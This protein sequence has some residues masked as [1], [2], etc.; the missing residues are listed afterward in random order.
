M[1]DEPAQAALRDGAR[2]TTATTTA[3]EPAGPVPRLS[4]ETMQGRVY[5]EMR[6]AL[7]QGRFRPGEV[8]T[9]R[10]LAEM[11][12][13][14]PMPV[15]EAIRRLVGDGSLELLKSGSARVPVL[16]LQRFDELTDV[17]AVLEGH[18]AARAAEQMESAAFAA[19]RASNEHLDRLFTAGDIP[20]LVNANKDFHFAVYRA[21]HS[22]VLFAS[23][24][25]L[26]QQ[27][28]PYLAELHQGTNKLPPIRYAQA[29][30]HHFDL[31]AAFAKGD[32]AGARAAMEADIRDSARIYRAVMFFG[33]T[34]DEAYSDPGA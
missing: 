32:A 12:G 28:G 7:L 31:I 30:G 5:R 19:I 8:L 17:R 18:A 23:I 11:L 27:G 14:S 4:H 16:T 10:G 15:R 9:V 1:A 34:A 3:E 33:R 13:T 20:A 2:A 21:A 22:E 6:A 29:V 25:S 26:W 24:E